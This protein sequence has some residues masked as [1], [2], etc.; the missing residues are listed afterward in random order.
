MI[1]L[2]ILSEI[3]TDQCMRLTSTLLSQYDFIEL[4][5]PINE[6]WCPFENFKNRFDDIFAKELIELSALARVS[7]DI[8]GKFGSKAII[9]TLT[10]D[11]KQCELS[12]RQ[13]CNKI[14]H[15]KTLE[16]DFAWS[17]K[18]PLDNGQNGYDESLAKTFK[19]PIIKTTGTYREKDWKAGIWFVK[20]IEVLRDIAT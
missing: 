9:G 19:N 3:V 16:V 1:C 15:A 2:P 8:D 5:H 17:D 12:F 18:H 20:Y 7:L 11:K 10:Q 6:Y 14:I 4:S 13:A